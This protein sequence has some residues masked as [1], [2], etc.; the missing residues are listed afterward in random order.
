MKIKFLLFVGFFF[1]LTALAF[2]QQSTAP[3]AI[4]VNIGTTVKKIDKNI[5]GLNI[6]WIEDGNFLWD[7][8][9]NVPT[10]ASWGDVQGLAPSVIRFPGGTFSDFYHWKDGVGPVAARPNRQPSSADGRVFDNAFGTDEFL[11]FTSKLGAEPFITVNVGSAT[12]AEAADWVRYCNVTGQIKKVKYWELGNELYL[13]GDPASSAVT[14]TPAVYAAKVVEFAKAMKNIDP[15]IKLAAIGG[16]NTGLYNMMQYSAW[17]QTVLQKAAP[18][19]DYL[20]VHNSYYPIVTDSNTYTKAELYP[21]LFGADSLIQ[22]NLKKLA[23]EISTFAPA[24]RTK[25][26]IAV[27]EWSS[28]F[29]WAP[30]GPYTEETRTLGSA[31]YMALM[32]KT[33]ISNDNVGM[34]HFFK[35]S[36]SDFM[37]LVQAGKKCPSYYA[38]Q[39]FSKDFGT[40]LLTTTTS[41]PKYNTSKRIGVIAPLTGVPSLEAIS[42]KDSSGNVYVIAINKDTVSAHTCTITFSGNSLTKFSGTMSL[43]SADDVTSK[44]A[45]LQNSMVSGTGKI[46][47]VLPKNSIAKFKLQIVK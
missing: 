43:L 22:D 5:L 28:L 12:S 15:A 17:D 19:I 41:C 31:I 36:G 27:T 9:Q 24:Y 33:Y 44:D 11:T 45:V 38:F 7:K 29:G 39:F 3:Y 34:V 35:L 21:A 30:D 8:T 32:L 13:N 25:I 40:D 4:N 18:Y 16:T 10:A 37:S 26:K 47:V 6:E 2:A 46:V 23:S 20:A 1:L 14:E 42:S